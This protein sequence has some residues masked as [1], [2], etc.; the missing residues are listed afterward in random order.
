M[1]TVDL[2]K[3]IGGVANKIDEYQTR[4]N[5]MSRTLEKAGKDLKDGD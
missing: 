4:I 2:Q 3:A 1:K 5:V